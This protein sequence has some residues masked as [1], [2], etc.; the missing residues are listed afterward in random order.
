MK[1]KV[2]DAHQDISTNILYATSKDFSKQHKLNEGQNNTGFAVH[3]NTDLPRLKIGGVKVVFAS[4]FSVDSKAIKQ[5]AKNRPD[6]YN[7]GKV[8]KIRTSLSGALEQL[9]LY[10]DLCTKLPGLRQVA[11][12]KDYKEIMTSD[13]VGLLF[14][15]EGIDY[16]EGSL[17]MVDTFYNLG[18]RSI[19]LTWRNKNLF[20]GGNNA[21]GGLTKQGQKLIKK[22]SQTPIVVDLAHSNKETFWDVVNMANFPLIV[23]HTLCEAIT[24]NTRNL[25]DEQIKAIAKTGG[26]VC[27]A[28]I[29]DF[30]GGDTIEEYVQHFVH[31]KKLVGVE[32]IGF[33]TDFD[34][35]IDHE[36]TFVK[37]F[38]DVSKFPNVIRGLKKSGFSDED[39]QKISYKNLERVILKR[40]S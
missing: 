32:H 13:K 31:V 17:D 22:L 36:D 5:L 34:G 20:G 26:V 4:I 12:V 30:I 25:D 40:L 3:N 35:L 9:S 11:S 29:P 15:L 7:F 23:S 39:I 6:N 10:H 28:A 27:M 33:G 14:H 21:K 24:A 18:V 1:L 2:I 16:F 37:N 8:F 38:D 19:A